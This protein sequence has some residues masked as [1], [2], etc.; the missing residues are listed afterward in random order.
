M[1]VL[2]S[3]RK[4]SR[5]E[6]LHNAYVIQR[7]IVLLLLRDF[8]AKAKV[9]TVKA[10]SSMYK[11]TEEDMKRLVEIMERYNITSITEEYPEWLINDMRQRVL[12]ECRMMIRNIIHANSIYPHNKEEF[13]DRR[14]YQTMAIGNCEQLIQE[15]QYVISIIN[16]DA[17]KYLPY[18]DMVDREVALL[19]GWRKSDNRLLTKIKENERQDAANELIAVERLANEIKEEQEQSANELPVN[20]NQEQ[21]ESSDETSEIV[22]GSISRVP[23]EV[24]EVN[25]SQ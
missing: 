24:L 6:F 17:N 12:Y 18:V 13:N 19:R 3:K 23:M 16:V 8:G 20:K 11:M 25:Q 21:E 10:F 22:T 9:R 1:S 5:L 7:S 15:L 4:T 2:K 14:R